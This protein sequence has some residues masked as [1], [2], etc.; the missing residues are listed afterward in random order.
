VIDLG[1]NNMGWEL[2]ED[3]FSDEVKIVFCS[4]E[5]QEKKIF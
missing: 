5:G 3:E 2:L 1:L 4:K